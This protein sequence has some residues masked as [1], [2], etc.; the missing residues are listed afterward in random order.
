MMRA[1]RNILHGPV[2]AKYSSLADAGLWRKFPY[3]LLLA[4]LFLFGCFPRLLTNQIVPDAT[5]VVSV[6]QS[7][8]L[9]RLNVEKPAMQTLSIANRQRMAENR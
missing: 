8:I 3:A 9:T 4:A 6:Y 1:A 7:S 5:K 2:P